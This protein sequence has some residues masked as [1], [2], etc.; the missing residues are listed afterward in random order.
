MMII[1]HIIIIIIIDSHH[2]KS[3]YDDIWGIALVIQGLLGVGGLMLLD[4]Q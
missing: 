4:Y 1:A 3:S 2:D